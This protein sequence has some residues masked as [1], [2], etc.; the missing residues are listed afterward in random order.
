M[1]SADCGLGTTL[2]VIGNLALAAPAGTVTLAGTVAAVVLSLR[3]E[4]VKPPEGAAP[5]S[6]TVPVEGSPPTTSVGLTVTFDRAAV[7]A[8]AGDGDGVGDGDG[9]VLTVQ[10]DSVG[11][12][13][14]AEPSLTATL[15][16][17]GLA[18]ESFL[19]LNRP[20]ASLV[21]METPL[22]GIRSEERRVGEE[23]RSRGW[24]YDLKK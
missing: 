11:V 22:T 7:D 2:V 13:A 23:G 14:L 5:V 9:D 12:A 24:A 16:S 15:Q 10:P 1:M 4:T 17:L 20:W 8:G 6:V 19:S 3:S 18:N 21:V